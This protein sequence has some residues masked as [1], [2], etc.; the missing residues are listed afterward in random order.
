MKLSKKLGSALIGG[1]LVTTATGFQAASYEH[2]EAQETE[3]LNT[4]LPADIKGDR[5]RAYFAAYENR[6][7]EAY[8]NWLLENRTE[9]ALGMA[10]L[11]A[12]VGQFQMDL[13]MFDIWTIGQVIEVDENTF[14]VLV[15]D[16]SHG[17]WRKVVFVFEEEAP[18]KIG[19]MALKPS[20]GPGKE[21]VF[22]FPWDN[23]G[24]FIDEYRA[25]SG[26]PA[27]ALGVMK[28]GAVVDIAA[29]GQR[30][31][32]GPEDFEFIDDKGEKH[33]K[34]PA[35]GQFFFKKN[36]DDEIDEALKK[37][38]AELGADTK[39]I[40][41]GEGDDELDEVLKKKMTEDGD[42]VQ[43][44]FMPENDVELDDKFHWGSITKSVT[45]TMI[46][47]LIEDGVLDWDT[48]VGEVLGD[49]EMRDEYKNAELWQVMGHQAG[50]PAYGNIDEDMAGRFQAYTGTETERRAQF[51]ADLMLEEPVRV[52]VYSNA[53]LTVAGYMAE[54]ATGRTWQDLV[55][56]HVFD[57]IG[58]DT[59]GFGWPV[60]KDDPNQPQGHFG[61]PGNY[62]P[63]PDGAME[64]LIKI[65][66]PAGDVHSSI[67]DLLKYGQFHL[68]GMNGKDGYL[69]AVTVQGLHTPQPGQEPVFGE[70]Y[71]FGWG[72]FCMGLEDAG[73]C[74]GHNGSGGTYFAEL[75]IYSEHNMVSAYLSNVFN[76]AEFYSMEVF[77]AMFDRY[78]R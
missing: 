78:S 46:G 19:P 53:G 58:M 23:L 35:D 20:M 28:D 45:G 72:H 12:R 24:E 75:Q 17:E 48:T 13:D 33:G 73:A 4:E 3:G 52:G 76:P 69:K 1:L 44:F 57:A 9:E 65:M 32:A 11:D 36:G 70:Q 38:L 50:F 41:K 42:D 77:R 56:E 6:D 40:F 21:V 67:G 34:P 64:T 49:L 59:A 55:Q 39:F 26:I 74:Q 15:K 43:F 47:K 7:P 14:E 22:D 18:F 54:V 68:D 8:R 25:Q 66:S 27:V 60:T 30:S 2:H 71:T 31:L 37:K 16:N 5:M 51:I 29:R 62:Q 61:S 10:P 63:Q